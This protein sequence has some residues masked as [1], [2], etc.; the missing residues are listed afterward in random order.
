MQ[1][2]ILASGKGSRLKNKTAKKPKCL[3]EVNKK[4]I[5]D[6]MT[7]L[8]YSNKTIIVTG[9]KSHLLKKKFGKEKVFYNKD[10]STTNMVHSLFSIN[11]KIEKDLIVVYSDIIFNSKII[12]DIKKI[13]STVIPVKRN[14]LR[15]WKLRMN[16]KKILDDAEDLKIRNK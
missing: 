3:V 9:Y 4:P 15:I 1:L 14:W 7:S 5:I 12:D 2:V 8:I 6:Y 11:K 13:N 10:F 16:R